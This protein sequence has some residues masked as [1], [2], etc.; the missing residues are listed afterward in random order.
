M[1]IV[2]EGG[3]AGVAPDPDVSLE[4][5]RLID[6]GLAD[7]LGTREIARRAADAFGL[8]RRDAYAR[9]L[10][11]ASERDQAAAKVRP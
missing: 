1:T 3:S 9:V 7:G 2:V 5:D 6:A 4:V 11:R 8:A 10:E